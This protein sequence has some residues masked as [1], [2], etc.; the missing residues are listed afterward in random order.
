MDKY[1][2]LLLKQHNITKKYYL[3][4]RVTSD[5]KTL[6]TYRGS[7]KRWLL[8]LAK[9]GDNIST[10]ILLI[11]RDLKTFK[12]ISSFYNK[13]WR[14]GENS[15][16]LNLKPED[17]DGG[18]T[19]KFS[20]N[21]DERK[22]KVSISLK[23]Y[24]STQE[25]KLTRIRCGETTSKLQRGKTMK[26][27]LGI[28]YNDSREGKKW[29]E[30]YEKSYKHP[31]QKPFK[32]TCSGKEWIFNNERE[33]KDT[34]GIHPDPVLRILKKEG[35]FTFKHVRKNSKHFFEKNNQLFF[36]WI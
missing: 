19:W 33:F 25:G 4:K 34:L 16:F 18:D 32:I 2:C 22:I 29:D 20:Q 8:H 1:I 31:Q 6:F 27:R 28:D 30:I 11:T 12:D 13:V 35:V 14:V 10:C 36:E 3:C 24:N 21:V 9:H 5:I 23:K 7:G 26:E 17:G 15:N